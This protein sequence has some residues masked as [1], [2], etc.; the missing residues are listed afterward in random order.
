MWTIFNKYKVTNVGKPVF[1]NLKLIYWNLAP[2]KKD[3]FK[4][5]LRTF[6][7]EKAIHPF[8]FV[9]SNALMVLMIFVNCFNIFYF[10]NV[11]TCNT[12]VCMHCMISKWNSQDRDYPPPCKLLITEVILKKKKYIYIRG[13]VFFL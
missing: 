5:N 10:P 7:F 8:V 2:N 3:F 9:T 1:K 13:L 11:N 6:Q 4:L 12:A